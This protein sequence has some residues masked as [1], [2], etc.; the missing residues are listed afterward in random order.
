MSNMEDNY[1]SLA[2]LYDKLMEDVDYDTWADFIDE[3]I[4][5]HHP[6]PEK[7]HEMACGT[8]TML[9]SMARLQCY[10]LSASDLSGDMVEIARQKMRHHKWKIPVEKVGFTDLDRENSYDVIFSVFDSVNYLHTPEE[11]LDMLRRT[12]KALKTNGI[13]IFD[14]STPQNSIEAVDYLN[15]EEGAYNRFRYFRSSKYDAKNNFH[16]NEF[17][18]EILGEDGVSVIKRSHEIHK[19]RIYS[20]KEMKRIINDSPYRI[21]SAYEDFDTIQASDKSSRVTMVLKCQ[22]QQ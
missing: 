16:Y 17:D 11:I 13:L 22:K 5:I 15:N 10:E 21:I 4:Q 6:H 20:F 2:P 14:F 19:Q 9:V 7:V 12:H 8:G 3:L 18:I 1:S